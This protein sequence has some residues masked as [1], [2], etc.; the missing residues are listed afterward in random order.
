MLS[1]GTR[2]RVALLCSRRAPGLDDLLADPNRGRL[3]DLVACISSEDAPPRGSRPVEQTG[4]PFLTHPLRAFHRR[5]RAPLSDKATRAFYDDAMVT[6]LAELRPDLVVLA[7]YRY[8]LAAPMLSAFP[9]R[10]INV[11]D[12]DLTQLDSHGRPRYPGLRA[13]RDA[14]Q[15]G[16]PE[17]RATAHFVTEE[18]DGGPLLLRSH[19]FPVAGLAGDVAGGY[20]AEMLKAYASVHRE[21]MLRAA[22]GPLLTRSIALVASGRVQVSGGTAWIDGVPGPLEL[23][24]GGELVRP[25]VR[26]GARAASGN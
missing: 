3:Y 21:W 12:A 24:A 15:A 10:I 25:P 1:T 23:T 2:L 9:D 22:W 26:S 7:G 5:M 20:A 8:V 11:H 17:T 13:V 6:V 14:V 19:A 18:L 4:V 16:E